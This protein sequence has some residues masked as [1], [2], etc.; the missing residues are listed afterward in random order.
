MIKMYEYITFHRANIISVVGLCLV[1]ILDWDSGIVLGVVMK[2]QLFCFLKFRAAL[3]TLERDSWIVLGVVM[4]AQLFCF[5]KFLAALSTLER[6]IAVI[7]KIKEKCTEIRI[8]HHN[9]KQMNGIL[10]KRVEYV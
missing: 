1:F 4:K 9:E 10:N 6:Y 8:F 7:A 2:A 5:R 3:S